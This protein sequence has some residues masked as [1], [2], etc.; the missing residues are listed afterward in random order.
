MDATVTRAVLV[1]LTRERIGL[2]KEDSRKAVDTL[3]Q[4]LEDQL[5]E[6]ESVKISGFGT[7][8]VKRKHPRLGRNP[9]TGTAITIGARKVV[10]FK[11]SQV[12]K[13]RV[14]K[15]GELRFTRRPGA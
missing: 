10:S 4:I 6:G 7:F 5:R 2:S 13:E 8:T 1:D 14:A 15:R 3:L 12:L 11:A 9:R